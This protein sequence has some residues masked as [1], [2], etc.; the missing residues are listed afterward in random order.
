M[1]KIVMIVVVAVLASS[2][3]FAQKARVVKKQDKKELRKLKKAQRKIDYEIS[4]AQGI[5]MIKDGDFVLMGDF[6][7]DRTGRSL[8]VV[9]N[10]NFV[11]VKGDQVVVQYALNGRTGL[12]G[13]GGVTYRGTIRKMSIKNFGEGKV[14]TVKIDFISPIM[15]GI[16]TVSIDIRG[17][18][19]S[20]KMI[21]NGSVIKL[22]GK[23]LSAGDALIVQG[24]N[25]AVL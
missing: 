5:Q 19:A 6:L 20:A 8:L 25:R 1:K 10:Y 4:K 18:Q 21:R 24:G 16:S 14:S 9:D 2:G 11:K 17:N 15:P 22:S 23:Y 3:L 13:I 12:N 7:S